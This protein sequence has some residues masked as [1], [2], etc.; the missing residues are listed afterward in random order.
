MVSPL[1]RAKHPRNLP[2]AVGAVVKADA[3]IAIAD[4]AHRLPSGIN[5][6]EWLN[7]LVGHAVVITLFD[8]GERIAV[9]SALDPAGHGVKGFLFPLPS[10][11]PVH[12]KVAAAYA[13][14][15]AHSDF[16]DLALQLFE[17]PN[18]AGGQGIA[19]VEKGVDKDPLHPVLFR[20][21]QEGVQMLLLRVNAAIGDQ[22]QQMQGASLFAGVLQRLHDHRMAEKFAGANQIVNAC[23]VH[24]HHAARADVQVTDFAVAHLAI[25]QTDEVIRSVKQTMRILRQEF[26]VSR[27][28]RQC[29]RIGEALRTITPAI[30][31]GEYNRFFQRHAYSPALTAARPR[32]SAPWPSSSSMR[33]NWLYFA[34]RSVRDAEPVLI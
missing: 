20:R 21:Q 10:A 34:M 31:N 29:Y 11:I 25:R 32:N 33:S 3:G 22:A 7:K 17:I 9:C 2:H 8:S 6:H 14:N 18:A 28:T 23:D 15:L 4:R 16:I 26:V 13:G 12:G 30:Q 5:H 27:L 24:V 19:A 1:L